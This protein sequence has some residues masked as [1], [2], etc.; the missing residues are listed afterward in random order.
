[1]EQI[2]QLIA[3]EG[4]EGGEGSREG[5]EKGRVLPVYNLLLEN[6][7]GPPRGQGVRKKKAFFQFSRVP[8]SQ[9]DRRQLIVTTTAVTCRVHSALNESTV[10]LPR[11]DLASC[12]SG[13]IVSLVIKSN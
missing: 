7:S 12:K 6:K 3:G 11:S 13:M 5:E 10:I 1:M 9:I 8:A 4:R 2:P